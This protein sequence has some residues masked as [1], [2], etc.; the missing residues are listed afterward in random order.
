MPKFPGSLTASNATI[1]DG[2]AIGFALGILKTAKAVLGV[3]KLLIFL[4]SGSEISIAS[5]GAPE[6]KL[7]VNKC[8]NS[9]L[10]SKNSRTPF[11]PSTTKSWY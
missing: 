11:L 1:N 4:S 5:L 3:F 6:N 8:C 9:K 10:E 7:V 2:S